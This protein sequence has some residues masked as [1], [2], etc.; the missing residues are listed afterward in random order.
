MK[1][2]MHSFLVFIA[3]F[4]ALYS[5]NNKCNE[6]NYHMN[7]ERLQTIDTVVNTAIKNKELPGA[8][9]LVGCHNQIIYHKAFGN[10]TVQPSIDPMVKDTI[11]D[12]AFLTKIFTA[13]AVVKLAEQGLIRIN[14]PVATYIPEFGKNGKEKITIEQLLLH[15]SGLIADNP[16]EEYANG[17]A[18]AFEN[19]CNLSPLQEPGTKFVYSD[20]G[21]IVLGELVQRISGQSLG[22]FMHKYIFKPLGMPDTMFLPPASL[23]SRI[24]PTEQRNGTWMQGEVHDPR[25]YA[26]GGIAGHAGLF[27]TTRD[28]AKV[29][30]MI[31]DNGFEK[32]RSLFSPLSIECMNRP[33]IIGTTNLRGLGW[34]I[35]TD[36]SSYRGDFFA[37]GAIG[38]SGFTGTSMVI[39]LATRTFIIILSNR[40][41]PDGKGNVV[42]L[43]AKIANVV[44]GS[45][46]AVKSCDE[47]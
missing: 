17:Y 8:V 18:K 19:I 32:E 15:S 46:T 40:V 44:A 38:H 22:A 9:V 45:L 34:D 14:T 28:L 21:Y 5:K 2:L 29:C 47:S 23:R 24:A 37:V 36:Y 27:S 42:A 4:G 41:H 30:W 16:E 35:A 10:R 39:D 1:Q 43:R 11:F 13:L 3:C 6:N 31:L 20:V 7:L 12:I 33:R 26:L 25:A